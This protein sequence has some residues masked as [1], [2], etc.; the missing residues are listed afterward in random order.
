MFKDKKYYDVYIY[1]F[2]A[3]SSFCIN[4][5]VG[6]NGVF[7]VDTFI[8][9]DN[10]YRILLGDVPI[11]DYWIVHGFIIDYMQAIFFKIFGNNWYSYLIHSSLFNVI[12]TIFSYYIFKFLKVDTS[13]AFILSISISI[14]AYPVSGTPFLDLH[15][16]YFSLLATY[17]IILGVVRDE[18]SYWLFGSILLC[19]AF[20]SKQV[21]AAYTIF[22]LSFVCLFISI[23]EKKLNTLIYF[24]LGA[25]LFLFLFLLFL[26]FNEIKFF[27]FVLQIF[28]SPSTIGTSRYDLYDL[29][30]KNVI[31]DF[32]FIYVILIPIILINL[33]KLIKEKKYYKSKDFKIFLII[34]VFSLS[35]LIHQIYTK[36]QIYIFSLIPI[37]SGFFLYYIQS[38][39]F[40]FKKF[41]I[42]LVI[43]FCIFV[44][45]KYHLRFND[46]RKFHELSNVNISNNVEARI[47]DKKLSGLNWIT[48]YFKDPNK[49]IDLI[50]STL[51]ILEHENDNIMFISQYN[52]FSAILEKNLNSPSR[53]YDLISYPRINTKYFKNYQFH[54]IQIIKKKSI[55]K[56]L[57]F[58]QLSKLDTNEIIYNYIPKNCFIET[59]KHE[60]LI[61]LKIKKCPELQ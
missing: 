5:Y 19:L 26:K 10:G 36:N 44:T 57:I 49:E 1:I 8:H 6:S 58:E 32:K 59:I 51:T 54:L 37:L 7:P 17:F 9:Y 15:S 53:T 42:Y 22:G 20:F 35:T 21:P 60:Y 45:F 56:I 13:F 14:L 23:S 48:P 39:S 31:L 61:Q 3:I 46:E 41:Y 12:I 38:N 43:F 27:D 50:K 33:N 24:I 52:F 34:S 29:S 30:F 11:K 2:L 47:I 25:T 4:F 28:L 40:K 55:N 18:N 16:T